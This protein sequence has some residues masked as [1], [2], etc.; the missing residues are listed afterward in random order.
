MA[1]RS[2][3]EEYVTLTEYQVLS[4]NEMSIVLNKVCQG[5]LPLDV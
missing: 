1:L 2:V 4:R 3:N 5:K